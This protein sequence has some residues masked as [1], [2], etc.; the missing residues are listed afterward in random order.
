MMQLRPAAHISPIV[1]LVI[2]LYWS[3]FARLWY[4]WETDQ[5]YGHGF[6]VPL[7]SLFLVWRARGKLKDI[8]KEPYTPSIW[9]LVGALLLH[10]VGF[11]GAIL[12]ASALSFVAVLTWLLVFFLGKLVVREIAF[13]LFFLLFMIPIPMLDRLSFPLKMLASRVSV[14]TIAMLG[15][16]VYREGAVIFL[17][18]FTMEVATACSGLKALV[19]VTAVGTLYAYLT[20]DT[21]KK[22]LALVAACM[23]IALL[24]N[25]GRIVIIALLSVRLST[26]KL[27]HLVHD[28]S[29]L[30]VY[31]IAGVLLAMTGGAIE[32]LSRRKRI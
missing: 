23:P 32:W 4:F 27:F 31:V 12:C 8:P 10:V 29:G 17:P 24:A 3:T 14:P 30:P 5:N 22:R 19:L 6:L 18:G 13:A 7:M 2:A 25:I 21:L 16:P 11:R 28:Y 20:L 15:I 1:G 9:L 26:E